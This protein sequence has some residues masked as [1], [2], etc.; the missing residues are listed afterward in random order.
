M[1][2]GFL[3]VSVSPK[4]TYLYLWRHQKTSNDSRNVPSMFGKYSFWKSRKIE[5]P[6]LCFCWK[7]GES[8]IPFVVGKDGRREIPTFLLIKS[9]TSWIWDQYLPE[10]MKLKWKGGTF[11]KPRNNK[12][13]N[14]DTFLFSSKG[15]PS[16]RQHTDSPPCTQ[17][18]G[19]YAHSRWQ[20][21]IE[22][23]AKSW[24]N[25]DL[26]SRGSGVPFFM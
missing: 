11:L 25:P 5:N 26:G 3:D 18:F 19:G 8:K 23:P 16:T 9:W 1:I 10:N 17:D 24:E 12:P 7:G 15:I 4:T 13:R 22:N 6:E 20:W 21:P 14:Q 2:S